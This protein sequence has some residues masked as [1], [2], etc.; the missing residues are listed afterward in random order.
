M[1]FRSFA[2][3]VNENLYDGLDDA[4]LAVAFMNQTAHV[5]FDRG[6]RW[7]TVRAVCAAVLKKPGLWYASLRWCA[8]LAWRA[9]KD[10][11]K[12]KGKVH[13]LSFFVHN[14]MDACQLEWERAESCIFMT[15]TGDG[16]I[17]MCVHNAKR[18]DFIL[19]PIAFMRKEEM[20]K[21]HPLSG[22]A[23]APNL[24]TSPPHTY[25]RRLKRGRT[26]QLDSQERTKP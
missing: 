20:L 4:E 21:W 18:D 17:S 15:M 25:P 19:K 7:A 11:L 23:V 5:A 22:D 13:K 6:N 1:L 3:V 8:R 16:P 10:I 12:A 26:R 9:R 2:F 24:T 14:F